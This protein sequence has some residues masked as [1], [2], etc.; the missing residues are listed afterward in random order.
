MRLLQKTV[1]GLFAVACLLLAAC[2]SNELADRT[3]PNAL[4]LPEVTIVEAASTAEAPG[5]YNFKGFVTT[6]AI[7]TTPTCGDSYIVVSEVKNALAGQ[8][9]VVQV[10]FATDEPKQFEKGKE[11]L[12]SAEITINETTQKREYEL[13]GYDRL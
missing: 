5:Q 7:C 13:L 8:S 2:D 1:L 12:F 3:H 11:Y 6:R 10:I 9:G 4:S